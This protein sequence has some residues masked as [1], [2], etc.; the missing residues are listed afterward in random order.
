[1]ASGRGPSAEAEH[2]GDSSAIRVNVL[3]NS[4]RAL[5]ISGVQADMAG[6]TPNR[7]S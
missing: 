7:I 1:V 5:F 3:N 4:T 6:A 2:I